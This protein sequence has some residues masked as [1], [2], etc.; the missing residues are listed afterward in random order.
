LVGAA[1]CIWTVISP[2]LSWDAGGPHIEPRFYLGLGWAVAGVLA[3][4]F[5]PR[6]KAR[7]SDK[8]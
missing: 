1:L 3:L 2:G 6:R 7:E 5:R 4:V 8:R